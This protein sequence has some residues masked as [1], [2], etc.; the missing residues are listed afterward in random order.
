MLARSLINLLGACCPCTAIANTQ[1]YATLGSRSETDTVDQAH[2][3]T[4]DDAAITADSQLDSRR[5]LNRPEI[6][7][8]GLYEYGD[9]GKGGC[10]GGGVGGGWAR[11]VGGGH[12]VQAEA[13]RDGGGEVGGDEAAPVRVGELAVRAAPILNQLVLR[14]AQRV[15]RRVGGGET[16]AQPL[17][18]RACGMQGE[19]EDRER[20]RETVNQRAGGNVPCS[21]VGRL[22]YLC[23]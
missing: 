16:L 10:R 13:L 21:G 1:H 4:E 15:G 23:V 18:E 17:G 14:L 11:L 2:H 12:V 9:K 22:I 5:T 20:Q 8:P 6:S 7:T 19:G 3:N